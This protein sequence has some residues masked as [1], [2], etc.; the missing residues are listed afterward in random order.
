[1]MM[2]KKLLEIATAAGTWKKQKK[3]ALFQTQWYLAAQIAMP[4]ILEVTGYSDP[5]GKPLFRHFVDE[6]HY[7]TFNE[8]TKKWNGDSLETI[9]LYDYMET[10]GEFGKTVAEFLEADRGGVW[11]IEYYE[12]EQ[13]REKRIRAA[14]KKSERINKHLREVTNPLPRGFASWARKVAH[15]PFSCV[16]LYQRGK[17]GFEERLFYV[18]HKNKL[19]EIVRAFTDEINGTWRSWFYGCGVAAGKK[20][21]FW[22]KKSQSIIS[23]IPRKCYLY[24][25]NLDELGLE[26]QVTETLRAF[27]GEYL[28]FGFLIYM[29]EK[30]PQWE[31]LAKQGFTEI[32]KDYIKLGSIYEEIP[33][34]AHGLTD[35]FGLLP[36]QAQRLKQYKDGGLKAVRVLQME[37]ERTPDD[38][39]R[40]LM[41]SPKQVIAI[42]KELTA[43]GHNMTQMIRTVVK[44]EKG[45]SIRVS[46]MSLYKDYLDMAEELGMNTK[47]KIVLKNKR[48]KEFHDTYL[49]EL[50]RR[51][52]EKGR[53]ARERKFKQIRKDYQRNR[54]IFEYRDAEFE[55]RVPECAEDIVQEGRAQHHCVGASDTYMQRMA[56][57]ESFILFLR[58]RKKPDT[59][60]YTIEC[61]ETKILQ[62]RSEY[63]RQPDL[64]QVQAFMEKVMRHAKRAIA[65][66]RKEAQ[67]AAAG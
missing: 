22:D 39:M 14:R 21:T 15:K 33:A 4:G 46:T 42:T 63:N 23:V 25:K 34:N 64:K 7:M 31:Y 5:K 28:D 24:M 27:E 29:A 59:P 60:F 2:K 50:N 51:R 56:R 13:N 44:A 12:S 41:R 61:T 3:K 30:R 6:T 18:D 10:D 19:L 37:R 26:K 36:E 55:I 57:R 17:T 9:I 48:W 65:K 58:K 54:T 47:D 53:K 38:V 40:I 52:D 11:E 8:N 20:Q 1:M 45:N 49:E 43:A 16:K 35:I 67:L 32:I 62:M 66:E